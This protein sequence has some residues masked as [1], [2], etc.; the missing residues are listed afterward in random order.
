MD[1]T[2][3]TPEV[4]MEVQDK[5]NSRPRKCLDYLTPNDIFRPS[6]PIALAA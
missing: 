3:L 1:F 2:T 5:L 6:P 4:V